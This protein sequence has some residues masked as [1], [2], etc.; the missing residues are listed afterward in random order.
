MTEARSGDGSQ[1]WRADSMSENETRGRDSIRSD[2]C[3]NDSTRD[4]T[5]EE[6]KRGWKT[7]VRCDGQA[8]VFVRMRASASHVLRSR[9]RS[10]RGEQ[11][12]FL[13]RRPPP[14]Q[15]PCAE[16]DGG[17]FVHY[18]AWREGVF[19]TRP[20]VLSTRPGARYNG[21]ERRGSLAVGRDLMYCE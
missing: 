2:R 8:P 5:R 7:L 17:I 14:V 19:L 13:L 10:Q 20:A 21:C 12:T 6:N 3:P 4:T 9:H 11:T 15:Q 16:S 18:V 1:S